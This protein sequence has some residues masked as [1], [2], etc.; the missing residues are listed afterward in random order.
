M[1]CAPVLLSVGGKSDFTNYPPKPGCKLDGKNSD[2][3]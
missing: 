3:E 1:N 2:L